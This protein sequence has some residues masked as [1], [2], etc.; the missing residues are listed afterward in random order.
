M[1]YPLPTTPETVLSLPTAYETVQPLPAVS[2]STNPI[3]SA[4]EVVLS[5][6][7]IPVTQIPVGFVPYYPPEITVE[8]EA[9]GE[10]SVVLGSVKSVI[11]DSNAVGESTADISSTRSVTV[12][13]TALGTSE[14]VVSTAE[15]VTADSTSEGTSS[16]VVA[17]AVTPESVAT[18]SSEVVV[19]PVISVESTATGTATA[20]ITKVGLVTV[21]S[22]A[23]GTSEATLVSFSPSGMNKSGTFT[24]TTA[25]TK[26]TGWTADTTNYPGSTV[27]SDAL[28]V[29]GGGTVTVSMSARILNASASQTRTA[30][31]RL[32]KNGTTVLATSAT[33][34]VPASDGTYTLSAPGVTVANG[35]LITAEML[36]SSFGQITLVAHADSWVRITQP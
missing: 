34:N 28:P 14:A 24:P 16:V 20:T 6:P 12:E 7:T 5:L 33:L 29:Q 30:Q 10:S 3:P 32:V 15:L 35:D 23:V 9:F 2:E 17:A 36:C 22:S 27:S 19:K 25:F 21:E 31:I 1:S 8:S 26:V 4:E 11:V 18:G 13:S